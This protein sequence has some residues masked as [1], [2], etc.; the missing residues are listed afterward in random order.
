MRAQNI[1]ISK[2]FKFSFIDLYF[3][4]WTLYCQLLQDW[5]RLS[6]PGITWEQETSKFSQ[7]V[8]YQ[9]WPGHGPHSLP[10][11]LY[12]SHISH[13]LFLLLPP[14]CLTNPIK[15][16][17]TALIRSGQDIFKV[18][19]QGYLQ[20]AIFL[21]TNKGYNCPRDHNNYGH[22][23]PSIT[24]GSTIPCKGAIIPCYKS[25]QTYKGGM[26]LVL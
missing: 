13:W 25:Y 8:L 22:F 6:L 20:L 19:K 24:T 11:F 1:F 15:C 16:V 2:H 10:P 3:M 26:L 17:R 14:T 12:L 23:S 21:C 9:Q 5:F 18:L 7:Q 4:P